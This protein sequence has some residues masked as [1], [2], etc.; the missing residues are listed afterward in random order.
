MLYYN[1]ARNFPGEADIKSECGALCVFEKKIKE[2]DTIEEIMGYEGIAA[3]KYFSALSKIVGDEFKFKGRNKRPPQDPFNSML[4]FA[5]T[6][7][8]YE[9]FAELDQRSINPYL[10]F[11]HQTKQSHPALV[12]DLLEEWRAVLVDSLVLSLIR[13][14]EIS[15]NEFSKDSSSKAVIISDKGIKI[16]I[17]K[18]ESKLNSSMNYL[19]ITENPMSY[20]RGIWWQVKSLAKC[21]EQEDVGLYKPLRLR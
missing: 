16:I 15:I 4:S 9:I 18:L 1:N 2:A 8:F 12:S 14:R 19:E 21:I 6:L 7:V 10:G 17:R 13:G 5:Y 3:R 11:I 20:R